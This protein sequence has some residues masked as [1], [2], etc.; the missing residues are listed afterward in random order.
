MRCPPSKN[1]VCKT[2]SEGAETERKVRYHRRL[3][4][5]NYHSIEAINQPLTSAIAGAISIAPQG[6]SL[7]SDLTPEA[8]VTRNQ[9]TCYR[10]EEWGGGW[11]IEEMW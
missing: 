3:G 6:R 10:G 1:L 4:Q 9:G 11:G 2:E 8:V 7:I 5:I